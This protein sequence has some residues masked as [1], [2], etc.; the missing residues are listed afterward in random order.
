MKIITLYTSPKNSGSFTQLIRT[1]EAVL[2]RGGVVHYISSKPFPLEKNERLIFHRFPFFCGN[3]L[4]FNSLFYALA[5]FQ[6]L[7]V[8][9]RSD[10]DKILLFNEEFAALAFPAKIFTGKKII[11]MIGGYIEALAKSKK[12]NPVISGIY[13]LYGKIGIFAASRIF[14][15][16]ED[17]KRRIMRFYGTR[18]IIEVFYNYVPRDRVSKAV[19]IDIKTLVGPASG[20]MVFVCVAQLIPRKNIRF[21]LSEFSSAKGAVS[22]RLLVVGSGPQEAELRS[23]IHSSG[24]DKKVFFLGQR[25]DALDIIKSAD[26]LV[27]PS[28]HDDCPLVLIE[29]LLVGTACIASRVGGIPEILGHE[30]LMFDPL[31]PG[32][33]SEK[34]GKFTADVSY[35][36]LLERLCAERKKIFDRDWGEEIVR[37]LD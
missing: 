24:I 20:G 28:T 21:L 13:F 11:L 19:D 15:V 22:A 7:Y 17:L 35:K 12:L 23:Y 4:L 26:L 37:I 2:S 30:E 8:S 10:A 18:K 6:I 29:S 14:A 5:P 36:E 27:L 32:E 3:E 9:L 31:R 33:L 16:S 25:K 1:V 34:L